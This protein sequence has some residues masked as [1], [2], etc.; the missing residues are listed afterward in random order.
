MLQ[1]IKVVSLL[2]SLKKATFSL[3]SHTPPI[4]KDIHKVN[5]FEQHNRNKKFKNI[6]FLYCMDNPRVNIDNDHD[7]RY[8][9]R[10]RCQHLSQQPKHL[11]QHHCVAQDE[12]QRLDGPRRSQSTDLVHN[13]QRPKQ[14]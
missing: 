6:H 11:R 9:R 8:S 10:Q 7:F 13:N 3:F 1:K 5:F 2:T 14:V 12:R 4:P